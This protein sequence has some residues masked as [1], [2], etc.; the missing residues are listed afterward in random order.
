MDHNEIISKYF[1]ITLNSRGTLRFPLEITL[2]FF[3]QTKT[4]QNRSL[5]L[6]QAYQKQMGVQNS[7]GLNNLAKIISF[8][9]NRFE[10]LDFLNP[11]FNAKPM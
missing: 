2:G 1:I 6:A 3:L 4:K 9:L 11:V 8:E 7:H 5:K 10:S